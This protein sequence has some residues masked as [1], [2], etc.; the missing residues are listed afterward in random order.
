M[1]ARIYLRCLHPWGS[2]VIGSI[3][4]LAGL[5]M[6]HGFLGAERSWPASLFLTV[7]LA[8]PLLV[9]S[10]LAGTAHELLHNPAALLL[11]GLHR[12]LRRITVAA[13]ALGAGAVT[14]A[15]FGL[16]PTVPPPATFGLAA[17]LLTA[18]FPNRYRILFGLPWVFGLAALWTF[19]VT[20]WGSALRPA[21]IAAPWT[22]GFAGLAVA[23]ASTIL[24]FARRHRRGRAT[25][26]YAALAPNNL[27][28]SFD[29]QVVLRVAE[30]QKSNL[31]Q[32]GRLQLPGGPDWSERRVAGG[33]RAWMQVLWHA[34]LGGR[35]RRGFWQVHALGFGGLL[36]LALLFPLVAVP[37]QHVLHSRPSVTFADY[38]TLLGHYADPWSQ[39]RATHGKGL[40]FVSFVAIFGQ[41]W[42]TLIVALLTPLPQ[43]N[44]PV[45][46][47]HL[48]RVVFAL[49]CRQ[50]AGALLVSVGVM[51]TA[52]L[53]GRLG[54]GQIPPAATY[55]NLAGAT[56]L[57]AVCL[58]LFLCGHFLRNRRFAGYWGV[59]AM[60]LLMLAGFTP[61]FVP[62]ERILAD[63]L[64]FILAGL[65]A[66]VT[67]LWWRIRHRYRHTDLNGEAGI[68]HS[69]I[70]V[71]LAK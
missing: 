1:N 39:L 28:L 44:Y 54:A 27:F 53:I 62:G 3:Y 45:S 71:R 4:G 52:G 69:G 57:I 16:D 64:P 18:C 22:F 43:L 48:A 68:F 19:F 25:T 50:L 58:P 10:F 55:V 32:E 5:I 34:G 63:G 49:V 35:P 11:P 51:L 2:L 20:T 26:P 23:A 13:V 14:L 24:L 65:A 38:W 12:R 70:Q 46:R 56:L 33:L 67:L 15:T 29:R 42:G 40:D 66:S 36:V 59:G 17:S 60:M 8:A 41:A 31:A 37:I 47:R 21:M 6:T 9:G 7:T 61:S 30:Q